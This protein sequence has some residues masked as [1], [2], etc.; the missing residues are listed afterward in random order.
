M[1]GWFWVRK[2]EIRTVFDGLYICFLI[3]IT[4]NP[5]NQPESLLWALS[6]EQCAAAKGP[7]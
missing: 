5:K 7:L 4:P 3:T 1:G 2:L 6:G